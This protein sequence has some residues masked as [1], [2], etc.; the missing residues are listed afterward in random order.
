VILKVHADGGRWAVGAADGQREA[1]SGQAAG[2][3]QAGGSP[4]GS[5]HDDGTA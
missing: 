1:D 3:E 2:G 4:D 5:G